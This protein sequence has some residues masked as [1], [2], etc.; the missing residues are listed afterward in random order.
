M[1]PDKSQNSKY[2]YRNKNAPN[3]ATRATLKFAPSSITCC[4]YNFEPISHANVLPIAQIFNLRENSRCC[5][6]TFF[7]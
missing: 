5:S 7:I 2:R 3:K 1:A 4:K 6:I